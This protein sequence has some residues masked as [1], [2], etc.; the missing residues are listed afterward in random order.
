MG[1][2][3]DQDKLD[4][5]HEMLSR[6]IADLGKLIGKYSA[7]YPLLE[8]IGAENVP[9]ILEQGPNVVHLLASLL[10]HELVSIEAK[11]SLT[12]AAAYLIWPLDIL[13]EGIIGPLGY[14]DDILVVVY[15]FNVMLNGTNL[16]DKEILTGLWK[17]RPADLET[18][19][20]KVLK[21]ESIKLAF[22]KFSL[23]KKKP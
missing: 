2:F 9:R 3:L 10:N 19:R 23:G 21:L 13:P 6:P 4:G 5:I 11:K 20:E 12:M 7:K 15:V 17:G 1:L 14:V 22:Q 18:L 16:Q 8:Q